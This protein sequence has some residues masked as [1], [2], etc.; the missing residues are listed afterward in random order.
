MNVFLVLFGHVVRVLLCVV[1][2]LFVC[3]YGMLFVR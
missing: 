1:R 3:R 2:V